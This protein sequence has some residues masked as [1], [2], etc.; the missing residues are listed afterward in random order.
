MR[1]ILIAMTISLLFVFEVVGQIKIVGRLVDLSGEPLI[2]AHL[3]LE[4]KDSI[5][6]TDLSDENGFFRF[7]ITKGKY[8][9]T[10][11]QYSKTLLNREYNFESDLDLG[12]LEIDN[13]LV[14]SEITI[15]SE[16]KIIENNTD[17][18]TYNVVND[19][20][21]KNVNIIDVFKRIPTLLIRNENQVSILGKD[22]V[23]YMINNKIL[24][25]P[26][27][28][29]KMLLS[30]MNSN[31]IEKIEVIP[32]P[33]S[34]YNADQNY[35]FINIITKKDESLG[36]KGSAFGN[37]IQNEKMSYTSGLN[38]MYYDS[39]FEASVSS[40]YSNFR[41]INQLDK[42][43][44]FEKH[45]QV[46]DSRSDFK[47]TPY[48]INSIL[49]YKAIKNV[50]IGTLVN[51]N[52]SKTSSWTTDKTIFNTTYPETTIDSVILTK[53]NSPAKPNYSFSLSG[54][55]D[56]K[57]DTLGNMLTFTYNHFIKN[58]ESE[59]NVNSRVD[60]S[61][62]KSDY[63]LSN[64]GK[65]KYLI[66]SWFLDLVL[67][68]KVLNIETGIAYSDINNRTRYHQE[69]QSE[70]NRFNYSEKTAAIYISANRAINTHWYIKGGLRYEHTHI[71]GNSLT[72]DSINKTDYGYLFPTFY[73]GWNS[74]KGHSVSLSYA[75]RI[76]R[77]SF[78]DLN[79]FRYYTTVFDY[80]AGNPSL[81]PRL[82][83]NLELKYSN[84]GNLYGVLYGYRLKKGIDYITTFSNDGKQ[85]TTPENHYN[86]NKI[87]LYLSY[88]INLFNWWNMSSS[89]D[90]F[91]SEF[92]T[93][94][95][96][97]NTENAYGLGSTLGL[98]SD[99]ILNPNKKTLFLH[100]SYL[101]I[102][103]KYESM[104]YYKSLALFD[105][106]MRYLLLDGKLSLAVRINDPFK[107]TYTKQS[108]SFSDY[109][110]RSIM[111]AHQRNIS[112]TVNYTFGKRNVKG[113]NKSQ[114][115]TEAYRSY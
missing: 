56:Y 63:L 7:N 49:K 64:L 105:M 109:T 92:K 96:Q 5:S 89:G 52:Q 54:Y 76:E 42:T 29:I 82:S 80:V 75:I 59:S 39:Q 12:M 60:Q 111:N 50:E 21:T 23:K 10:I 38:L 1:K 68:S 17:R 6:I 2:Y 88:R 24:E 30:S 79:P 94:K 46:S 77:P 13:S 97:F 85:H 57:I 115:E 84:G 18:I 66:N 51:Y 43:Y 62:N 58:E 26:N 15:L 106:N 45:D 16:K 40:D 74:K 65:N 28:A 107:Q 22:R 99:W 86:Q 37:I 71:K 47:M 101:H 11:Q 55:A 61:S 90:I 20:Y 108:R 87:G 19:P 35:G 69:D 36:L 8:T 14:L 67:P 34:K 91:Y 113:V 25:L 100:V 78:N 73:L 48:N 93:Y 33:P 32:T 103:P 112:F 53:S 95:S 27:E 104:S 102:F 4:N 31:N 114:K 110:Y 81:T 41:G 70:D 9:L 44:I 72:L 98:Q 3:K 83:H